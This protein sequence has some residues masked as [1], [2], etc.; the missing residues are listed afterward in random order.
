MTRRDV[1]IRIATF[2]IVTYAWSSVFMYAVI[3][4]GEITALTAFGG[5][6]SPLVGV[7]VTRLVFP[8]GRRRGSLAGLG[9]GWGG[10]RFQLWSVA[11]PIIYVGATYVAVWLAGVGSIVDAP[12]SGIWIFILKYTAK[13]LLLG[14]VFAFGEEVGWQGF[15][16]PLLSRVTGFTG[17]AVARG[18]VWSVWHFPL[19]LGGVYGATDTPAWYRLICFT[20]T[21]TGVSFAF[22]WIRLRS[23]SL[24]TGVFM[25]A[26]HNAFIQ[27]IYP[28]ITED[29]GRMSWYVDEFGA[30]TALAA[31]GVAVFFW[32]KRAELNAPDWVELG[33]RRDSQDCARG[34]EDTRSRGT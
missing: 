34:F 16:V 31:V 18:L 12:A 29:G 23:G 30:W 4:S 1:W 21:M 24:W 5:M 8:D 10:T 7:F 19:I 32:L 22:T 33:V 2:A 28:G 15:M 14:S 27:T 3:A 13:G 26:S 25:H 17:T 20:I 6:W 11:I 9:W